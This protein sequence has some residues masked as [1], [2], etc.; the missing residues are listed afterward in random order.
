MAQD[1]SGRFQVDK[2][3]SV[4]LEDDEGLDV[5]GDEFLSAMTLSPHQE[6]Y[7]NQTTYFTH[8]M[9][10]LSNYTCEV[11]PREEYYRLSEIGKPQHRPSV[12]QLL[13]N[14][15]DNKPKDAEVSTRFGFFC[16]FYFV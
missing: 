12:H 5:L 7:R 9:K 11:M 8:Y 10:T 4:S 14:I 15:W 16:L 2:V 3:N 6:T 13:D 1:T